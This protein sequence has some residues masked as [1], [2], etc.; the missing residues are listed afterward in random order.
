PY[1][2][3]PQETGIELEK[4]RQEDYQRW[5][6]FEEYLETIRGMKGGEVM[7]F[8]RPPDPIFHALLHP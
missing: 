7:Q 2:M 6:N 1:P 4:M 3:T 5:V 8:P